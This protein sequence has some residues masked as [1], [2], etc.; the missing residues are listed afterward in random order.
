MSPQ[1]KE[2]VQMVK[3]DTDKY[4]RIASQYRIEGLPT[5]V[6]FSEDGKVLDRMEGVVQ[7]PQLVERV[8]YFLAGLESQQAEST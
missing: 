4:P 6:L 3:I 2:K 1:L 5:L 7:G 8:N